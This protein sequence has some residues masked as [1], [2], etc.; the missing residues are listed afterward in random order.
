MCAAFGDD[1]GKINLS[2]FPCEM[3]MSSLGCE[4]KT[5]HDG[6]V[7]CMA[8]SFDG[9]FLVSV[10]ANDLCLFIWRVIMIPEE[11]KGFSEDL[12]SILHK[13]KR[14]EEDKRTPILSGPEDEEVME[15]VPDYYVGLISPPK[16]K[17]APA[18]EG[19]GSLPR[20]HLKLAH[21]HS[22]RGFDSRG[23][24]GILRH[25]GNLVYF[26]AGMVQC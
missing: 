10:G 2:P 8:F 14:L 16:R 4:R 22:Y 13:F 24:L 23:N 11:S 12:E 3:D 21:C 26:C 20:E 9:K 17:N 6:P 5:A 7:A 1:F 18:R 19:Y 25:A 15:L